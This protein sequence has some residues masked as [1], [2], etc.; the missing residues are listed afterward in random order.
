MAHE[1]PGFDVES[2]DKSGTLVRRI[3]VKSTAAEWSV[4][5]VMMSQRQ[6]DQ[7]RTDGDLFWLD[8]VEYAEDDDQARVYRIQDPANRISYFGF[9]GDWKVVAEPD[10]A[11][12]DGGT[13]TAPNTRR[14]FSDSP[15][16]PSS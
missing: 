1:N 9:D 5:G 2:V 4:M 7:A 14:F 8:V 12:D 13:P 11:R 15:G 16:Q 6:I 3:E 10:V